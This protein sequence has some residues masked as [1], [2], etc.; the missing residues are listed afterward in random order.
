MSERWSDGRHAQATS[1]GAVAEEYAA[2]RPSYPADAVRWLVGDARLIVEV[3]A[4]TG[5]LTASLAALAPVVATEPLPEMLAVLRSTVPAALPVAGAAEA[6]PVRSAVAGVVVA[7]Q[8]F[9]WFDGPA[10][11]RS[12]ARVLRPRG[13]LALVWNTRDEREPWVAELT[14]IIGGRDHLLPSWDDCFAG[15]AFEHPE[16]RQFAFRQRHD[17]ASLFAMVASRSYLA[18]AADAKRR[19]VLSDVRR[20][21]ANHPDLA[22][23][24]TFDLPYVVDCY[25]ARLRSA[26]P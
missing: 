18:V 22:G 8:A 15:S 1:F 5:K 13:A 23:R 26:P 14:A 10:A 6:I 19:Q 12:A 25:R 20:L 11:L 16:H 21:A 24:S 3:G 4:G 9:H 7:A 2:G 17:V